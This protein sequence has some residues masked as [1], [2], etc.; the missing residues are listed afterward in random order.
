MKKISYFI[1]IFLVF[2]EIISIFF[3]HL[4]LFIFNEKPKYSFEKKFLNDWIINENDEIIWHK[5]NYKTRHSARCFDVE[6]KTNNI[7]ARDN[8]DYF[9]NPD[10][11]SILL[12]GDSFAEGVGVEIDNIFAKV[13]EKKIDKKVFN[14]GASGT[15]PRHQLNKYIATGKDLNFNE[16]IYFFLPQNDYIKPLK[17]KS[18]INKI[19]N[20]EKPLDLGQ[21]KY[22]I[23]NILARFTYS[24]NFL[25]SA[26]YILN[27]N[28]SYGYEN[29]SYF[30]KDKESID[31]TL[32]YVENIIQQKKIKSYVLIIPTIYDINNF[33]KNKTNYK[34][35]YWFKELSQISKRN[36]ITLIDL[37]DYI[38]FKKKHLYF[39]SCDGHWSRYG[40]FF[41]AE[42]FLKHY[43]LK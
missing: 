9:N 36:N 14:F 17:D 19:S 37:M 29:L 25:R 22:Q 23:A 7:G 41:A 10:S 8:N 38:N 1:L 33:Q 4:E 21:I 13:V 26:A 28:L 34:D 12:I 27:T 42:V 2:F 3:T 31:Y 35:F 39:H 30:F 16:L 40:N 6:Y 18:K 43:H 15:N 32:D 5:K 11:N 20:K 24:Y